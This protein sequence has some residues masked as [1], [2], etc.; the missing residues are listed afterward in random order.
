MREKVQSIINNLVA[1]YE[2]PYESINLFSNVSNKDE[3]EKSVSIRISEPDYPVDEERK[4]VRSKSF[5]VM[6]IPAKNE[7]E[8]I[9]RKKQ[10]RAIRLSPNVNARIKEDKVYTHVVFDGNLDE[11][12]YYYIEKNIRFCIENFSS[13][14]SFGCCSKYHLCSEAGKCIHENKLYA[15]GCSYRSNLEAGKVFFSKSTL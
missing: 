13:S 9:I 12:A 8:L 4:Q 5:T 14:T 3:N 1:E 2:L 7:L 6:N 15:K 11:E 10:Y